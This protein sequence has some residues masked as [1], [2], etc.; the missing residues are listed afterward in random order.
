[1]QCEEEA[2]AI[3]RSERNKKEESAKAVAK[4][5]ENT[6]GGFLETFK[7]YKEKKGKKGRQPKD[8]ENRETWSTLSRFRCYISPNDRCS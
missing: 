1:M 7:R 3:A 8:K 2:D 4:E 5:E 6:V